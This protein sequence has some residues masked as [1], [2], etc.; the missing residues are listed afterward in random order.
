MVRLSGPA[1]RIPCIPLGTI[2]HRLKR[3]LRSNGGETRERAGK[4]THGRNLSRSLRDHVVNVLRGGVI[5]FPVVR[6]IDRRRAVAQRMIAFDA[7]RL[8]RV[9]TISF[10]SVPRS[11]LSR[12]QSR[13]LRRRI[14]PFR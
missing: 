1:T 14:R 11:L 7:Y 2:S 5:R 6:S 12:L 4:L 10:L 3:M 8:V 9:G 13:I